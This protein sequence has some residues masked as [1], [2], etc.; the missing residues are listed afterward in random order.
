MNNEVVVRYV[1]QGYLQGVPACDLTEEMIAETGKTIDELVETGLYV[2][3]HN[4]HT[5]N[6]TEEA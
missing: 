2:G 5:E 6:L 3:T 1:G 4:P